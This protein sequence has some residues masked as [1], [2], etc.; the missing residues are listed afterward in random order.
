MKKILVYLL[1]ASPLLATVLPFTSRAAYNPASAKSYLASKPQN[2]WTTMGLVALGE[3]NPNLEHLK[4]VAGGQAI[5]YAAPILALTAAGKNPAVFGSEDYVAKLKS[6]YSQGQIGDPVSLNDDIFGLLALVSAGEAKNSPAVS[7]TKDYILNHQ[8]ANGG[9]GYATSA[10]GDTDMT[11]AAILALLAAGTDKQDAKIQTAVAFLKT[12]Q[13]ENGGFLSSPAFDTAANTSSTAWAVWA[14]NALGIDPGSWNKGENNP[15]TYLENAQ[16]EAGWFAY[17]NGSME[18]GFT[19]VTSAYALIALSG[20]SLPIKILP[21]APLQ[22]FNFRIEG[23]SETVCEG[24][25]QAVNALEIIK[26]ASGQCGYAYTIQDTQYGPY[27]SQIGSDAGE[28]LSGWQFAVNL[29]LPSIGAADYILKTN[30]QVLWYYGSWDDKLTRLALDKTS[31]T[32]GQSV[33]ATVEYQNS[34]VW[35]PLEGASI[36]MGPTNM[37]T[38]ENGQ[39]TLNGSDGYYRVVAKKPG[40]VRSNSFLLKIGEPQNSSVSLSV[41]IPGVNGEE[42]PPPTKPE[43]AFSI[44]PG[45]LDFGDLSAGQHLEKILVFNNTGSKDLNVQSVIDGDE[46]FKDNLR[47]QNQT[48]SKYQEQVNSGEQASVPVQLSIPASFPGYGRKQGQ[49]IFWVQAQ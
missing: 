9:W 39:A 10:P 12:N 23:K 45:N 2:S 21:A 40:Y 4:S 14:L 17:Q 37:T 44:N 1:L 19:P 47:L 28:S 31:A 38:G 7:G 8:A 25:V 48:W 46:V 6:Y 33:V 43:I 24:R 3:N 20:K 15:I 30:D 22:S 41:N 27:L 35:Q 11:A 34:G 32:S 16:N 49:I 26:N 18:D 42:T 13:T 36:S 29:T 5:A